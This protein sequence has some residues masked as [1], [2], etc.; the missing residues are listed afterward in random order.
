[1]TNLLQQFK[2]QLTSNLDLLSI[3]ICVKHSDCS[4]P[5]LPIFLHM[6]W[7]GATITTQLPG[8]LVVGLLHRAA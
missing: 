8:T 4:S 6:Y 7:R 5:D 3:L 2:G 1:M